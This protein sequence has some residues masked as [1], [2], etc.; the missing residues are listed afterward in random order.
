MS[1]DK[2]EIYVM[3][4]GQ[5]SRLAWQP[6]Y[7]AQDLAHWAGLKI[8]RFGMPDE[9][10][11]RRVLAPHPVVTLLCQGQT[12]SRLRYG[13]QDVTTQCRANDLMCYSG[14]KEIDY[15]HWH[16]RN[17]MLVS[18]E[19]D[20]A[21]L[22]EL[23]AGDTRFTQKPLV[24]A[25]KFNDPDL[26]AV[27]RA[28]WREVQTGCPK[29]RLY[30]DALSLGLAAHVHRRFGTLE[31]SLRDDRLEARSRLTT[32]QLRRID[33]YIRL[34]LGDSIGLAD[35]ANEAGLSRY[36]FTRL[37]S[38]TVGV[39]PYQHVLQKRLERAYHLLMS[40]TTPV[41]EVALAAGFSSQSH[42][43]TVCKRLMGATPRQLRERR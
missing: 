27:I 6:A 15:A 2:N 34:H 41:A 17:A 9:V 36:H 40:T 37:F 25:P 33:D 30:T 23:E 4:E 35:L 5:R 13:L 42:F 11:D 16:S 10:I 24:G 39:S 26:A 28:L 31:N 32:S 7:R 12:S 3:K 22:S 29:G 14:G 8:V 1:E 21:R 38:N 43:T 18:V 20:P 19:L